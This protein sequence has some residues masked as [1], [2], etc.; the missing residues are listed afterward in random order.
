MR[1]VVALYFITP[2][3][4]KLTMLTQRDDVYDTVGKGMA[5]DSDV[6]ECSYETKNVCDSD[7]CTRP[8]RD[9]ARCPNNGCEADGRQCRSNG[10]PLS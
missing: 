9:C 5:G 7:I 4:P 8:V 3:M 2:S 6:C 1:C 10:V